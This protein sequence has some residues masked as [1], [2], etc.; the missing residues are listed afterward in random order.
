[1]HQQ[2]DN[3]LSLSGQEE[4]SAFLSPSPNRLAVSE[5]THLYTGLER[6]VNTGNSVEDYRA[7]G[8][9][10]PGFWPKKLVNPRGN[11][12]A[13]HDDCHD[14][15]VVFRKALQ[16]VWT[17]SPDELK[18][19]TLAFLLG[20][21]GEFQTLEARKHVFLPIA[22][23]L[24]E[25]WDKIKRHHPSGSDVTP[26]AINPRWMAGDFAYIPSNDFQRALYLLFQES[27]RAKICARCSTYFVA[28]K[29]AQLYCG[30][31]CS[32]GVKRERTLKW[33]REKGAKLRA[34]KAKALKN[35]D[36]MKQGGRKR[37]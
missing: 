26:L 5:R 35:Q 22:H 18:R 4:H 6:F 23:G 17:P 25:A 7:L 10:W 31:A 37:R 1:M 2:H 3:G 21:G 32:G 14:L 36:R 27:W 19:G 8:K 11:S 9:G 13:W 33:W 24:N 28:S 16:H 20:I 12:L 30:T 15:F 34:E 29:P